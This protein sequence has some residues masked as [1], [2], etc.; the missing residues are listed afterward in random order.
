MPS[1]FLAAPGP[2][3][4]LR[5]RPRADV[6]E[7][8]V[9]AGDRAVWAWALLP[10]VEGLLASPRKASI[11]TPDRTNSREIGSPSATTPSVLGIEG[12]YDSLT[13]RGI[14]MIDWIQGPARVGGVWSAAGHAFV[15]SAQMHVLSRGRPF[16]LKEFRKEVAAALKSVIVGY[17][18]NVSSPGV[19]DEPDRAFREHGGAGDDGAVAGCLVLARGD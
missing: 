15:N 4:V 9:S 2:H 6:F 10:G 19:A 11:S 17:M 16:D 5:G 7:V 18:S 3:E 13:D 12:L 8:L 14:A 1:L